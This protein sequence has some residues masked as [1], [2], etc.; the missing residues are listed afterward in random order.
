MILVSGI[1]IFL[2]FGFQKGALTHWK[3][4]GKAITSGDLSQL[5]RLTV[6]DYSRNS[7]RKDSILTTDKLR[8]SGTSGSVLSTSSS[9]DKPY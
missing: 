7:F 6:N 4:I 8:T 9:S 2:P 1:A 5:S 3:N